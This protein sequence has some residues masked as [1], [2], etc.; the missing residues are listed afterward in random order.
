MNCPELENQIALYV[1]GD[2]SEKELIKVE[3]HLS[4]CNSCTQFMVELQ[5][6]Q[7]ALVK[8]GQIDISEAVFTS[9]RASVLAEIAVKTEKIT[10]WQQVFNFCYGWRYALVTSL[11]VMMISVPTYFLFLGKNTSSIEQNVKLNSEVTEKIT[12]PL[13]NIKEPSTK[14]RA[15]T[16]NQVIAV[17]N[18]QAKVVKYSHK[19]SKASRVNKQINSIDNEPKTLETANLD[20]KILPNITATVQG[21]QTPVKMEIQT[22]NP[23]IRIIWL[24]NKEEKTSEKST[25]S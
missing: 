21:Q 16:A 20:N 6:S 24:V 3:K 4:I 12:V 7:L 22:N 5:E 19:V 10:W 23:N 2:L 18:N 8:F 17:S 14:G 9:L 11:I 1:S 13:N 25:N 15:E